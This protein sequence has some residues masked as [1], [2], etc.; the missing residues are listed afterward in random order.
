MNLVKPVKGLVLSAGFGTRL[1]PITLTCPKCLVK[2]GDK[3]I[4]EHWLAALQ[5]INCSEAII[6][7][8]YL[9]DKVEQYLSI[10]PHKRIKIT[11]SYE[12]QILGTAGTLKKHSNA[13]KDS[14]VVM[15]HSDNFSDIDLKDVLETHNHR[16]NYCL[17]TMVVFNSSEP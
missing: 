6:N 3:P 15:M 17:M 11:T 9:F 12:K 1:Q 7:T 16:P 4:L 10:R 14:T 2:V 8:H 5:Q 13:L